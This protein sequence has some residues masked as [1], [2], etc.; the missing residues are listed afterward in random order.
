MAKGI[1]S[2]GVD[3]DDLFDPDVKGDGITAWWITSAGVPLRY[4][5]LAY[6][7]K[8]AD[9]GWRD[10]AGV[11]V[12]NYWAAKGTARY[13]LPINGQTFT[14][15]YSAPTNQTGTAFATVTVALAS[16]G[17][18]TVTR[19]VRTGTTQLA[20]GTWETSP[21]SFDVRMIAEDTGGDSSG[22]Y[23]DTGYRNAGTSASR[24][25]SVPSNSAQSKDGNGR[26]R[27][28]I[29]RAGQGDGG[30]VSD[31]TIYTNVAANG[32]V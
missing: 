14:A 28:I 16:N 9:V 32:W 31:T 15:G 4:A 19:G 8:R 18:Y 20:S 10:S 5:K 3:F 27:I 6:G 17:T 26:I 29:S 22:G 25:V 13:A 12:S 21:G 30:I 1:Y 23:V 11:D 24:T 7:S 2:G